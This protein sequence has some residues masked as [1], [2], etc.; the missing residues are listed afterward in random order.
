MKT[1]L[2]GGSPSPWLPIGRACRAVAARAW[3][4]GLALLLPIGWARA[5]PAEARPPAEA[6]YRHADMD[7]AALSPSGRKLALTSG[8]GGG[9]GAG[10]VRLM[11]FDLESDAPPVQVAGFKDA[12]I[13]RFQWVNDDRLVFSLIDRSRAGG[14]Q[15][16]WHGL[17]SV[18]PDGSEQRQSIKIRSH[19]VAEA[20][21]G[22]K[23]PLD[24]NHHLLTVPLGGGDEVVVGVDRYDGRNNLIEVGAKRLNVITQ[25]TTSLSAGVP[26]HVVRWWFDPLGEPRVLASWFEGE[27]RIYWRGP[28]QKEW[29][30]LARFPA[31]ERRFWPA[32]VDADGVLYVTQASG[33]AGVAVLKRFDF[34]RRRPQAEATVSTP[35]FDFSGSFVVDGDGRKLLGVRVLTD[36]ETTAWFSPRM[37]ALQQRVDARLPGRI[38]RLSC[39]R[40][41]NDDAVLLIDSY[42]D[43][44]PGEYWVFHPDGERWQKVGRVRPE[45]DAAKMATLDLHRIEARDGADLPVWVTRPP[46]PSGPRPAVVLVHGGPWVR[47]GSWHWDADAQFLASRGYVVIEPEFRGSTGYGAAHFRAG[48]KQWGGTMQDD[49]ADALKWA[50]AKGWVDGSRVCIAGASYGGYATLMGLARYPELYRCGIAWVAVTDPRLMYSID[51]ASDI[52]DE[53]KL[54]RYPALIGDPVTDAALLKAASAVELAPRI[55]APL[56]LVYGSSDVRVPLEHGQKMRDALKAVGHPPEWLV[57]GGEGHG[58]LQSENRIDF[59]QR[60]ESFLARNLK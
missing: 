45:I 42:S 22:A 32:F 25:S 36:A 20:R 52:G 23:E 55:V 37:K 3:A 27:N 1:E 39:R 47:G 15:R 26:D 59:A 46:A 54:Y 33:P 49:V 48:W 29:V 2:C 43:Q 28:G 35:G 24:W 60:I 56:L 38:N 17:F 58:W 16:F 6:F 51:A 13:E 30:E 41:E 21:P 31:L 7:Q 18:R 5:A 9:A 40:C 4:M 12:D 11:V 44:E 14:E 10:R 8:L 57:Y 19:W 34:E 50:V 53:F